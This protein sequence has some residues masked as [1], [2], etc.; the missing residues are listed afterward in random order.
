MRLAIIGQQAFGKSVL[1]AFVAR[2]A[3]VAGV[4]CAPEKPG[5]KPDPL[6]TAAEERRVRGFQLPSQ[7]GA[8]A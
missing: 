8:Q 2:G 7:K 1:E 3:T 5:T 6:R 4:F